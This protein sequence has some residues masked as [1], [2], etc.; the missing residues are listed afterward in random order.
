MKENQG[1]TIDNKKKSRS[2]I[3]DTAKLKKPEKKTSIQASQ[4]KKE[5]QL[6]KK[7]KKAEEEKK[8]VNERLL[9]TLA[10]LDNMRKRTEREISH[11]L[12]NANAELIKSILFVVDDFERSFK[13]SKQGN[14]EEFIKGVELI[15]QK[16]IST[17]QSQ[18]LEPIESVGEPF[19]VEKHE[20]LLQVEKKGVQPG[21]VVEEHE[22]GYFFNGNVLRHAKVLVSK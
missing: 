3:D 12:R 9:R 10:E 6:R 21:I 4:K 19:D 11:I 17:L 7:L 14:N 16:L 15:Y 5:E 20:A 22:K 8:I 18:G 2:R 1:A 13:I